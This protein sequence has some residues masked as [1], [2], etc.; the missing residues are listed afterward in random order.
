MITRLEVAAGQ[1]IAIRYG[2]VFAWTTPDASASLLAFLIE[3]AR[4][5]AGSPEAGQLLVDHLASV[6]NAGDPEPKV[7]FAVAGPGRSGWVGIVHGPAQAWDGTSW[8]TT[9]EQP[10]WTRIACNPTPAL[11]FNGAGAALP[12][13]SPSS[14]FD[15]EAGVVP[16]GGLTA[17]PDTTLEMVPAAMTASGRSGT[18]QP[19]PDEATTTMAITNVAADAGLD[20]TDATHRPLNRDVQPLAGGFPSSFG[21]VGEAEFT[22]ET[23]SDAARTA[24]TAVVDLR[25]SLDGRSQSA[26][27]ALPQVGAPNLTGGR[28]ISVEGVRC[29]RGHLNRPGMIFCA[30]CS[31]PIRDGEEPPEPGPRPPL[32]CLITADGSV[33]RLDTGYIVGPEDDSPLGI[34]SEAGT[35]LRDRK[36]AD[37][38]GRRLYV[39]ATALMQGRAEILL[40]G[41]DAVIVDGGSEVGTYLYPPGA[42]AWQRMAPR[43]T[44]ILAPGSHISFG[45]DVVTYINP[46][47]PAASMTDST[48]KATG[49]S[50]DTLSQGQAGP[51]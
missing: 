40:E 26:K 49:T 48:T 43:T 6:L 47:V 25:P 33:Y 38:P 1:G 20:V 36:T 8:T 13:R 9:G 18:S 34:P 31:S 10:G 44:T 3:S 2:H 16:G 17:W 46:W 37:R 12:Q 21:I 19:G 22:D 42:T 14:V 50:T 4:N 41:W 28:N 35:T 45:R 11:S 27:T 32:G 24:A 5:L 30:V 7:G 51:Q 39:G 29:H 15:L 23:A